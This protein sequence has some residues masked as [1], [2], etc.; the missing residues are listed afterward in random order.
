MNPPLRRASLLILALL[1]GACDAGRRNAADSAAFET[2][3][4]R[5]PA[6]L[7]ALDIPRQQ[8]NI[9]TLGKF[10]V[11][12]TNDL[13]VQKG[14]L[15]FIVDDELILT[16]DEAKA[17]YFRRFLEAVFPNVMGGPTAFP[18]TLDVGAPHFES[19]DSYVS[20]LRKSTEEDKKR[21]SK[22]HPDKPYP[23]APHDYDALRADL[24][25]QMGGADALVLRYVDAKNKGR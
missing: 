11:V 23:F 1:L 24:L 8:K 15:S 3:W 25:K 10:V 6:S 9:F 18:G 14:R 12:E 17:R 19:I 20:G 16:A 22:E 7:S 2:R 21:W 4:L 13:Y 5:S